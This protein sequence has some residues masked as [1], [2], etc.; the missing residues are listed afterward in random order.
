MRVEVGGG[1][2]KREEAWVGGLG[3]AVA[4]ETRQDTDASACTVSK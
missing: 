1:E 3:D 2:R 4:R